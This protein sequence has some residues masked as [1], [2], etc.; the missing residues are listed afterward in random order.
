MLLCCANDGT[1]N[2]VESEINTTSARNES[3]EL[4]QQNVQNYVFACS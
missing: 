4:E 3:K 2:I 1:L